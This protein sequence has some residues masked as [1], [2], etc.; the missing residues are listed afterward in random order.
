[1]SPVRL[2]PRSRRLAQWIA[3]LAS[4][5]LVAF[6][7][8]SSF[9]ASGPRPSA[10]PK[11]VAV[12]GN[13]VAVVHWKAASA[14]SPVNHYR[15]AAL[16]HGAVKVRKTVGRVTHTTIGGLRNGARYT[17]RVVA[18]NAN[19]GGPPRGSHAVTIGAPIAPSGVTSRSVS[20]GMRVRWHA[21]GAK[22]GSP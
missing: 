5:A 14:K 21:P 4:V 9:A 12:P 6:V 2:Q 1:M 11:V 17:F 19:G 13:G 20:A 16:L 10:P 8:V 15:V 18:Q 3:V 22:N 7:A